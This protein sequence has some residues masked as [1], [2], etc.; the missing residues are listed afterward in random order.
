VLT[1]RVKIKRFLA[2]A[3]R[4]VDLA[5]DSDSYVDDFGKIPVFCD[6]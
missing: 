2:R 6:D 3:F 5:F 1:K 4:S